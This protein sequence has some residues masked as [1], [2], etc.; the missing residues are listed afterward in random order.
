MTKKRFVW[1]SSTRHGQIYDKITKKNLHGSRETLKELNKI[2]DM[3]GRFEKH[4]QELIQENIRLSE[5]SDY[6]D[7][8]CESYKQFYGEDI[9]K[10][11]W[12]GYVG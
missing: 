7:N 8:L 4:N 3:V 12:F 1:D 6:C 9:E 2:W 10:A 5:K 11:D